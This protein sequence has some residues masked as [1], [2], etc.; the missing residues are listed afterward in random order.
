MGDVLGRND[1]ALRAR[2]KEREN[3]TGQTADIYCTE[4]YNQNSKFNNYDK[5]SYFQKY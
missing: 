4:K 2:R 3:P 5:K 1:D